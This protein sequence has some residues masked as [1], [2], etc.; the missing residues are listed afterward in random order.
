M[1]PAL[2]YVLVL[3]IFLILHFRLE[4]VSFNGSLMCFGEQVSWVEVL[5]FYYYF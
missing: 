1:Y 3:F 2:W 5:L 4:T